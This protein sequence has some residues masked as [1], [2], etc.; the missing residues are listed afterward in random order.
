M[1]Y[2]LSIKYILIVSLLLIGALP[3]VKAETTNP[4]SSP[5]SFETLKKEARESESPD[6]WKRVINNAQA[7]KDTADLGFAYASYL[8]AMANMRPTGFKEEARPIMTFLL[9]TRQYDY[10]F[11]LYNLLI[12]RLFSDQAYRQAQ[13]EAELM[14][15]QAKGI[16]QPVGMAMALRVQGQIFYKLNLY[17]KAYSVLREG[18][19]TCPSYKESLNAFTTAQSL[20]E[21]QIMT[22]QKAER[23]EEMLP[24]AD[25]YGEMLAYWNGKGWKDPSGHYPV[26]H[27]SLRAIALL[28]AGRKEEARDCLREA[29]TYML[30]AFPAVLTSISM[31]PVIYCVTRKVPIKRR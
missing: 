8:Q 26:T 14:Y 9:D 13:E 29:R 4:V 2:F 11:A 23:Y 15:Q 21:W 22:C 6:D 28:K 25:L 16:G 17:E 10:Y 19:Q 24:L 7:R 20:C 3:Y 27:L 30:P 18:S 1:K 12:N 5:D 31:R